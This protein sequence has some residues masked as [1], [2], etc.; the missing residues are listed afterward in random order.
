M[1]RLGKLQD[2]WRL[3]NWLY[4][5]AL[6]VP[7]HKVRHVMPITLG[8][9]SHTQFPYWLSTLVADDDAHSR[10]LAY[11]HSDEIEQ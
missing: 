11:K 2:D 10:M 8:F 4:K 5:Q 6:V 3:V 9:D 1:T 7:W